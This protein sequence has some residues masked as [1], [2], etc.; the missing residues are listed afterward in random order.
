MQALH[1]LSLLCV[2]ILTLPLFSLQSVRRCRHSACFPYLMHEH[3]NIP[4]VLNTLCMKCRLSARLPYFMCGHAGTPGVQKY[5]TLFAFSSLSV[6][7]CGSSVGC[8]YF[9]SETADA[10]RD[11]HRCPHCVCENVDNPCAFQTYDRK[12]IHSVRTC[13][14]STCLRAVKM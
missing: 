12:C 2:Y 7:Q 3:V 11:F 5:K 6:Q 13:R 8:P 9:I 1:A 4:L 10:P 14:R